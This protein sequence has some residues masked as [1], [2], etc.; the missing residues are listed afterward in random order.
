MSKKKKHDD[1]EEHI[2][3]SWLIPYADLLT[4]LLALFIVLFASSSVDA[5][6]FKQISESFSTIFNGGTGVMTYPNETIPNNTNGPANKDTNKGNGKT[7]QKELQNLQSKIDQYIVQNKL[8]GSLKTTLTDEGLLITITN[9]ILFDSGSAVVRTNERDIA[10]QISKLL[11]S[12]PPLNVIV[13]GHTDN[14]PIQNNLFESNWDLS[15]SRAVNFMKIMLEN[16]NLK[17][18]SFSA[19]GYGE[20]KPISS[21]RTEI[22][23]AKNRRVEILVLP[24][25][26][27]SQTK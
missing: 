13:S 23:R 18:Q 24:R 27:S 4:L 11:V 16:K 21:N 26:T 1:H 9:D 17:P 15:V 8:Q 10:V 19:K 7:D 2:D 20:F 6:K 25:G 22:G 3:E 5:T 14:I 12:N